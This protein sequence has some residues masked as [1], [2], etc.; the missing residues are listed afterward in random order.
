MLRIISA[1]EELWAGAAVQG[2]V[3]LAGAGAPVSWQGRAG[4]A[5]GTHPDPALA[6][7]QVNRGC[8]ELLLT[9]TV[10]PLYA[11][12][13]LFLQYLVEVRKLLGS[14]KK[15]RRN[16]YFYVTKNFV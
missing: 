5:P 1:L 8:A 10:S 6:Q 12:L 7:P 14:L 16:K 9:T 4:A 13:F 11:S 2:A 3:A 15:E